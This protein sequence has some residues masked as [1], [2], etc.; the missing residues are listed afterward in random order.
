M[1][2]NVSGFNVW[3]N[4]S[5]MNGCITKYCSCLLIVVQTKPSLPAEVLGDNLMKS[6]ISIMLKEKQNL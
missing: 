4:T 6:G 3:A 5:Y 2:L 1:G